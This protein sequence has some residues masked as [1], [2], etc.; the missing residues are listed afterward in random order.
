MITKNLEALK[1][2]FM[3]K[4]LD[5]GADRK[6]KV[7]PMKFDI[8]QY[9]IEGV[10]NLSVMKGTAMLGLMKMDTFILTPSKM[11][12]PLFSYD[13]IF[14]M[15][16]DTIIVEIYDTMLDKEA[17]GYIKNTE[18]M[19]SVKAS[20][21]TEH[22]HEVGEHWYDS[23]KLDTSYSKKGKKVTETFDKQYLELFD[24]Y[25]QMLL[26]AKE[27]DESS[28]KIASKK[29]VD[30]LFENGGPSTDQFV[31]AIGK[32]AAKKLFY[33]VIFGVE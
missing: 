29:Y 28:K 21:G 33:K 3:V 5:I 14:A 25:L 16:N 26:D 8:S 23:I 18:K 24:A 22:D 9:E 17:A 10:G 20:F 4:S 6:H 1:T 31:K 7:G 27:C 19:R 12:A 30:G 15:G 11:D 2:K 13:R 32:D